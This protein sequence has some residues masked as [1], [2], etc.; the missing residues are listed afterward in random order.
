MI[1]GIGITEISNYN[2]N[3][4]KH[5]RKLFNTPAYE[6]VCK[7]EINWD[8]LLKMY[9]TGILLQFSLNQVNV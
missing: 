4:R 8:V 6:V 5:S 1:L 9:E 3:K 2:L 7:G